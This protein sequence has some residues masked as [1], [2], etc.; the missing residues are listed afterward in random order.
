MLAFRCEFQHF[1]YDPTQAVCVIVA[2][3]VLRV[4]GAQI[5]ALDCRSISVCVHRN[6]IRANEACALALPTAA[7]YQRRDVWHSSWC[8]QFI[9]RYLRAKPRRYS[10][11]HVALVQLGSDVENMH[12]ALRTYTK[13]AKCMFFSWQR[14]LLEDAE[15]RLF[16]V[17]LQDGLL[18]ATSATSQSLCLTTTR[19]PLS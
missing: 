15:Q 2:S 8:I 6:Q 3:S 9:L 10:Y 14:Y 12:K 13:H 17:A 18:S 16:D 11:E 5:A 4:C 1:V 7:L 19:T